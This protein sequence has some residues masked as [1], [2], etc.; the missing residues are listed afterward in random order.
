VARHRLN[1]SVANQRGEEKVQCSLVNGRLVSKLLSVEKLFKGRH[2]DAEI[3]VLCVRWYLQF[4]LVLV[5]V[6][7]A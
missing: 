1:G 2:F 5:Q 4:K 6:E 7:D 3:I